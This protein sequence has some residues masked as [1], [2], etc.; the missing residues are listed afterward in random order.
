MLG[1]SALILLTDVP[2]IHD[3]RKRHLHELTPD[4][5]ESLIA[6]GDITGGMIPK[7]RAAANTAK[8]S[9][10]PV[11]ILSGNDQA[12]LGEWL[13]GAPVG[14]RIVPAEVAARA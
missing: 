3:S 1:A 13:A 9:G 5:V 4:H 12:A 11:V 6:S 8:T 2:G 14:T 10:I 7:A